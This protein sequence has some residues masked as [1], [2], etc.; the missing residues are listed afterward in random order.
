LWKVVFGCVLGVE[1]TGLRGSGKGCF[2]RLSF[3]LWVEFRMLGVG[4]LERENSG[5]E[6]VVEFGLELLA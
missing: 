5:D 6:G 2:G 1:G 4:V 3:L